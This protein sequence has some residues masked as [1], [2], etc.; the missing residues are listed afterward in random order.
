M[1]ENFKVGKSEW[2]QFL[3]AVGPSSLGCVWNQLVLTCSVDFLSVTRRTVVWS[4]E[5]GLNISL[6]DL[7]RCRSL[8][9]YLHQLEE[10]FP[11][12][13]KAWRVTRDPHYEFNGG[14]SFAQR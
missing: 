7:F 14:E 8:G 13:W 4:R 1:Q 6:E 12:A 9:F 3:V 5:L 2:K 11:Q 10:Q